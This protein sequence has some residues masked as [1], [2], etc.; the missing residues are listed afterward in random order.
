MI[1]QDF[2]VAM[3]QIAEG[4]R[5][6]GFTTGGVSYTYNQEGDTMTGSFVIPVTPSVDVATG[7][8]SY[9]A[10]DAFNPPA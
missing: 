10:K 2:L 7:V 8:L 1:A 5:K 4:T 3:F 9:E 6:E